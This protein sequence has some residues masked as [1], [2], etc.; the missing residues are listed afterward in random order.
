MRVMVDNFKRMP[1]ILKILTMAVLAPVAFV[2]NTLFPNASIVA[3]GQH[4]T[5]SDWWSSG[6]GFVTLL[7]GLFAGWA[8]LLLLQRARHARE[9]YVVLLI[10]MPVSAA[11]LAHLRGQPVPIPLP[12]SLAGNGVVIALVAFYLFRNK[13]VCAYF[14]ARWRTTDVVPD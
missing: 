11:F 6:V 13:D 5:A 10:G 1:F 8:G 4:V 7:M 3:F 12:V 9:V 2:V 14:A